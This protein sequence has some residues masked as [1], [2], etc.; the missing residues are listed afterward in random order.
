MGRK[1]KKGK[2]GRPRGSRNTGAA[3]AGSFMRQAEGEWSRLYAQVEPQ[4]Y[5][6]N[7]IAPL[8]GKAQIAISGGGVAIR[9]GRPPKGAAGGRGGTIP[10]IILSTMHGGPMKMAEILGALPPGVNRLSAK[11]ALHKMG[12]AG[13]LKKLKHGVYQKP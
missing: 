7:Q 5:M 8:I 13:Q 3:T 10:Q 11:Q 1:K 9:R 4:I 12:S 2:R 6:M